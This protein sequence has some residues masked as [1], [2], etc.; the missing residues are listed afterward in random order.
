MTPPPSLD[1][2]PTHAETLPSLP[3][4]VNYLIR[5]LGDDSANLDTLAHHI[6]S[7]PAIVAR[8]LAAANSAGSGLSKRVASRI[9]SYNVCYTK[10]LR[11]RMAS[12]TASGSV[13]ELSAT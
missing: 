7:D 13:V 1:S 3:E 8:L 9:T 12:R 2:L 4:V 10:L 5:A 11:S 6:N